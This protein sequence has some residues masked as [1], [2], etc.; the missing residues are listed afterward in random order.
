MQANSE[1]AQILRE[2]NSYSDKVQ[3]AV[4][5]IHRIQGDLQNA[6]I[7]HYFMMQTVLNPEQKKLLLKLTHGEEN[8]PPCHAT[9][10]SNVWRR[11][12][13]KQ[14]AKTSTS[15]VSVLSWLSEITGQTSFVIF[16]FAL[17][18]IASVLLSGIYQKKVMTETKGGK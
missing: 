14:K 11:I 15:P 4:R 1:L 12:K 10:E 18:I 8:I 17:T 3:A 2:E 16:A 9:V 5:N 13:L 6:T 7:D